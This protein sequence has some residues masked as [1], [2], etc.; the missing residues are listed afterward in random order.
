MSSSLLRRPADTEGMIHRIRPET[1]GWTYLG[2]DVHLIPPGER[3]QS[4]TG[5]R[6]HCLVFVSGR[7]RV[8]VDGQPIGDIGQRE[9]PFDGTP[10]AVYVPLRSSWIVEAVT[11]VE[12]AVCSAPGGGDHRPRLVVPEPRF[13]RG[14]GSN[15]RYVTNIL[16][17]AGEAHALLILEVITPAGHTSSW[18]SHRHDRDD[19]PNETQLEEIFYHRLDPAQGF[20][21][22]RVYTDDGV[23]DESMAV[24][25]R[26]VV[27]VPRGYHPCTAMH[28]YSLYSLTVMAGPLRK[29]HFHTQPEHE[30]VL[31]A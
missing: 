30:W 22:Q 28:G 8:I 7:G 25:D 24:H 13:A 15:G 31:K 21:F 10:S 20:A 14:K 17:E 27:L 1:V 9:S 23:I 11:P 12:L 29:Q 6:E 26:D 5:G 2:L 16:G 19:P 18:P 4:P 3:A